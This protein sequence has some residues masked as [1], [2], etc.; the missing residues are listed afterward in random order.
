MIHIHVQSSDC[1]VFCGD[2]CRVGI[3][4]GL[5]GGTGGLNPLVHVYRRSFLSENRLFQ[6][7]GKISYISA[8]DPPPRSFRSIPTRSVWV[9]WAYSW[10]LIN[11]CSRTLFTWL[12]DIVDRRTSKPM[13]VVEGATRFDLNQGEI[14]KPVSLWLI[15]IRLLRILTVTGCYPVLARERCRISPP[16]YLSMI[17]WPSFLYVFVYKLLNVLWI[18]YN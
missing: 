2:L 7:L 6:S 17:L 12:Q 3:V 9:I 8:A 4:G 14:G 5:E 13:F 18:Q 15:Y 16:C 11:V 1:H 10:T